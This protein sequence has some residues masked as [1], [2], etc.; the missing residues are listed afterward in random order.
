MT[1]QGDIF[2]G[3]E[4]EAGSAFEKISGHDLV[5]RWNRDWGSGKQLQVQAF[6]DRMMRDSD[7]NAGSFHVDT[8]DLDVQDS[9]P[10]DSRNQLVWG[11]GSRAAHYQIN[12]TPSLFFVS[13][14]RDLFLANL[15]VQDAYSP[16][17][18]VSLTAGLKAEHDPYV[19]FSLLPNVR[20]AVKPSASTLLWGAVSHA[21]RSPTPF[22]EDVQERVATVV[23]LSGNPDFRTEK[24]T[25][26]E[27]GLRAQPMPALSFSMTAFII[28]TMI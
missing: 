19:G 27:L 1:F 24:L 20:I 21:V 14:S 7:P 18:A 15:F 17:Q 6:Y 16:S 12:G 3:R 13:D 11:G 9:L 25:A 23:A 2:G 4:N 8:Y 28:I 26:Y 10:L 22:D 5:L